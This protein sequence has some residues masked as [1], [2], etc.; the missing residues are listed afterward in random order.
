[1]NEKEYTL[2]IFLD[3]KGAFK[4]VTR[5]A[6]IESLIHLKINTKLVCWI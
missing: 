6:I 4:N 5:E 1:L 2:A 3:I